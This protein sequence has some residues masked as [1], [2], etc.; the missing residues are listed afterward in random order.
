MAATLQQRAARYTAAWGACYGLFVAIGVTRDSLDGAG[1]VS[2]SF[3]GVIILAA[4]AL[5][6]RVARN[7]LIVPT[8]WFLGIFGGMQ[9]LGI[10]GLLMTGMFSPGVWPV[11]VLAFG[12]ATLAFGTVHLLVKRARQPPVDVDTFD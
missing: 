3:H 9:A 1:Y 12:M 5:A 7:E 2:L 11:L 4:W 10:V 8:A 6:W